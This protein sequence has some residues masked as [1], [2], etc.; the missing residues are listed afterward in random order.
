MDIEGMLTKLIL[1]IIN[2]LNGTLFI[3]VIFNVN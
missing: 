2:L 3:A 1:L